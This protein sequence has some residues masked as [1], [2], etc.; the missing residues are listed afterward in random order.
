MSKPLKIIA[1][2]VAV[3]VYRFVEEPARRRLRGKPSPDIA[4]PLKAA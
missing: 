4:V 2:V 3:L 1:A